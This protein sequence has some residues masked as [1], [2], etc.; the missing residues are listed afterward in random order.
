MTRVA[1]APVERTVETDY[2][3]DR[4]YVFVCGLERSGTTLLAS[5]L[6]KLE[7]CTGFKNTGVMKD[8]GQYLQDVYRNDPKFGG[9]GRYGFNRRAHLTEASDLLTAE[10]VTRLGKSWHSHW[11]SR[12]SICLEKT[13]GNLIRT[14]FLQAAF[15]NSYFIVIKRHPIAVSIATQKWSL[16]PL[17]KLF[18]HWLRYY[19]LFEQDKRHLENLYELTYEDYINHPARHH[20][21]IAGFLGTHAPAVEM[22]EVSDAHNQRYFDRWER[23]LS[24]SRWKHYHRF[25]AAKYDSSFAKYG[26]FLTKDFRTTEEKRQAHGETSFASGCLYCLAANLVM[27]PWRVIRRTQWWLERQLRARSPR[28]IKTIVKRLRA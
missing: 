15:P 8:E 6:A 26:Y 12:K 21:D 14:R 1:S 18:E 3:I 19:E 27:F 17:H 9:A 10:N 23:L 20:Q 28:P 2:K 16:T 5:N 4:K 7:D 11:D 13:P 22:E 25:I 24:D